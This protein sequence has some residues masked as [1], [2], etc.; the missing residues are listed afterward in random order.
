MIR[1]PVSFGEL[2]DKITILQ[3][4]NER[5]ADP[6]KLRNVRKELALLEDIVAQSLP[7]SNGVSGLVQH[8]K[9][10]N[11]MLW[12]IEEHIRQCENSQDFGP[13]FIELARSVYHENDR[14]G[15]LKRQ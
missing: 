4:K 3:I 14:R 6:R 13:R 12:D 15:A 8:L 9:A 11:E 5:I 1:V 2:L 10:V 7:P